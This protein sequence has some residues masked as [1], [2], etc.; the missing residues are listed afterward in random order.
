MKIENIRFIHFLTATLIVELFMLFLFRFTNSP[1]TGQAINH[2]YTSFRWVAILLDTLSV[3]IGF[4]IAK[5]VY[6]YF[7]NK[8]LITKKQAL[9]KFL[10]IVLAVQIVHDFAFY[11]LVIKN[12]TIGQND[13]M[14]AFIYY[15]EKVKAG[16][17]IGDSFMYLLAT[18]LLL[19]LTNYST[20]TNTFISLICLYILGYFVYQKPLITQV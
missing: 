19:A 3:L 11:F 18:P 8:E 7:V 1:F 10:T 4:Y 5:Y 6:L 9:L 17:V 2:W 13:I 15:A 20:D 12:T 16:A 14:D